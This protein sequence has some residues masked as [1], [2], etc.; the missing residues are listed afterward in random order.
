MGWPSVLC[1]AGLAKLYLAMSTRRVG[2]SKLPFRA[3]SLDLLLPD[4]NTR[5]T[6]TDGGLATTTCLVGCNGYR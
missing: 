1:R 6:T 3:F 2:I 5:C 4:G